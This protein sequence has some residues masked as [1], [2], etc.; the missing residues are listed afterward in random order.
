MNSKLHEIPYRDLA[1]FSMPCDKLEFNFIDLQLG[2]IAQTAGIDIMDE[3]YALQ[4]RCTIQIKHYPN[5]EVDF[6][7]TLELVIQ[8]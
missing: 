2:T 4:F 6:F 1:R 7:S 5:I 3:K 8:F